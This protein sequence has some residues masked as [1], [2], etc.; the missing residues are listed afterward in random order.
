MASQ[1]FYKLAL[2]AL[3]ATTMLAAM[4]ASASWLSDLFSPSVSSSNAADPIADIINAEQKKCAAGE[5]GTMGAAI[6]DAVKVHTQ[7][8]SV[9][10]DVEKLFSIDNSCFSGLTRL[11]D[12][13]FAIPSI[14]SIAGAVQ[15]ALEKY[16]AQKVC[17][18]V[19]E[20]TALV[21]GPINQVIGQINSQYGGDA[22]NGMI[23]TALSGIDPNLGS[24]YLSSPAM[25]TYTLSTNG[26]SMSQLS[27]VN[28]NTTPSGKID[29]TNGSLSSSTGSTNAPPSTGTSNSSTGTSIFNMGN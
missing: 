5:A 25:P 14:A 20:Q 3:T 1:K 12:L 9:A 24:E 21:T 2:T 8:A 13:S 4:P 7:I 26:L 19:K 15:S 16:A 27:F 18:F 29:T 10:P 23:G 28:G 11:N 22:I 6:K 17:T